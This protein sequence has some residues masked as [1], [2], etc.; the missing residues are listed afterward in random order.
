MALFLWWFCGSSSPQFEESP[1]L[2][3][4][5]SPWRPMPTRRGLGARE[6]EAWI[7]SLAEAPKLHVAKLLR[8]NREEAELLANHT[9]NLEKHYGKHHEQKR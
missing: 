6:E 7:L 8:K 1:Q 9:I 5:A 4:G 2:C 3:G